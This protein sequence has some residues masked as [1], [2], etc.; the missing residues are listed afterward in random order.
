MTN[1]P[2]QKKKWKSS[3][4][5]IKLFNQQILIAKGLTSKDF[6]VWFAKI[7]GDSNIPDGDGRPS[8]RTLFGDGYYA[9]WTSDGGIRNVAHEATH[10]AWNLLNDRGVKMDEEILA[11]MI[12]HITDNY[13]KELL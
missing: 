8:G 1:K 3:A 10:I 11:Y 13:V 4:F 12:G 5:T 2:T 9:M 6:N 7:S